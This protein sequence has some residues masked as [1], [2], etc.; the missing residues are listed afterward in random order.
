MKQFT[1][2]PYIGPNSRRIKYK[3]D[4]F[5]VW[6]QRRHILLSTCDTD[7]LYTETYPFTTLI[8]NNQWGDQLSTRIRH[9]YFRAFHVWSRPVN[10][11]ML[12]SHSYY[13]NIR[14]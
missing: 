9:D 7:P 13:M 4:T 10:L 2:F 8:I 6:I 5:L 3:K 14:A 12:A 1:V 11:L